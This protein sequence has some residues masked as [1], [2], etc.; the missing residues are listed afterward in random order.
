MLASSPKSETVMCLTEKIC[1]FHSEMS[2]GV[3]VK[4]NVN[5]STKHIK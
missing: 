2:Y 3:T 5:E 1:K 4:F